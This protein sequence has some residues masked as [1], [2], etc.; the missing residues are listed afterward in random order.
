[1]PYSGPHHASPKHLHRYVDEFSF[2]LNDGN[3]RVR[4]LDRLDLFVSATA[5]KRITYKE[6]IH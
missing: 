6:L 1:M 2:R 4:T 5:G 3:V